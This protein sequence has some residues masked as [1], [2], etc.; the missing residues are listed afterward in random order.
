MNVY[1]ESNFVLEHALQQEQSHSCREIIR[2]ASAGQITLVV[3]AFSLAEPHQA[4]TAKAK[5]RSRLGEDLRRH[6]G[7]LGRS[8]PHREVPATF[9]VL[10]AV[11]IE[12]AQVERDALRQAVSEF[13]SKAEIIPLDAL[14]LRSAADIEA[15]FGLSGQDS[16]VLASVLGHLEAN[17]PDHSCFLNR[18]SGD[19]DDPDILDRLEGLHCKFFPNFTPA[20]SYVASRVRS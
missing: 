10:A 16:I 19:F 18:N 12:S 14:V 3:P 1:V 9:D 4:I 2:L 15:T 5:A 20:F 11:L 8:K 17:R 13:L 7:E 6:L